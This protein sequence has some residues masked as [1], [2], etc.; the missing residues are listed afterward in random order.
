MSEV[1]F[2]G[3][4]RRLMLFLTGGSIYFALEMLWRG[5]SHFTMF[6]AGGCC[7]LL[8]GRLEKTDPRLSAIPRGLLGATVITSVEL[9]IG[10]L[11]NG[12]YG[13]W[14]YRDMPLNFHGQIC[15]PFFLLWMPL[16]LG[17][18]KLYRLVD[19]GIRNIVLR[20]GFR[21]HTDKRPSS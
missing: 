19:A 14:D 2:V 20:R 9:L 15:L 4:L 6:L 12:E 10:I 11:A 1:I 16:S 17:A 18:M 3:F 8:L 7:F 21:E 13:I 5:W